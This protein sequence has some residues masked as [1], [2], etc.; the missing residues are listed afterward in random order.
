M[1]SIG[2]GEKPRALHV[3]LEDSARAWKVNHDPPF[4]APTMTGE[5]KAGVVDL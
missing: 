3:V 2:L 1:S 5:E 4:C